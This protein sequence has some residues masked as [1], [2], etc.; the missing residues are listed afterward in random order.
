MTSLEN[1]Q[2]M[3]NTLRSSGCEKFVLLKFTNA[4]PA[5]PEAVNIK[6]IP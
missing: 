6:K 5:L 3:T 2:L 1:L 4:Y